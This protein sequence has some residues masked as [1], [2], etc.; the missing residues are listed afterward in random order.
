MTQTLV[1]LAA[2]LSSRFGSNKQLAP[3]GPKDEVLLDYAV[4]D[5]VRAGYEQITFVIRRELAGDFQSHV[6]KKF[7]Q[8]LSVDFAFQELTDLPKGFAVP[9]NRKKPWGTAHGVFA[10]RNVVQNPFVVINADDFYGA[11]AYSLLYDHLNASYM[12]AK[13]EF[14]MIGYTLSETFSKFGGVSRGICDVDDQGYLGQLVEV[15]TISNIDGEIAGMTLAGDPAPLRGDETVSMN[16]WGLT[17]A[18]FEMLEKQFA[19]FLVEH[20]EDPDAEFLISSALN[21]QISAGD[22][23]L[24]VLPTHDQWIGMTFHEDREEVKRQIADLVARGDYPNNLSAWF[25]GQK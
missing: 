17:P 10:T 11:A 1:V 15:K 21:E 6:H 7:G 3:V 25:L 19:Q 16:I 12:S 8:R 23:S 14:S 4:Y 2:G 24:K 13:P 18:V 22:V 20:L 5:A 9:S